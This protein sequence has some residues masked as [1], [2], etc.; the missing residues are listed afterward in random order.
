MQNAIWMDGYGWATFQKKIL[1]KA[2]RYDDDD[3]IFN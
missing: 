3:R 2:N 1:S